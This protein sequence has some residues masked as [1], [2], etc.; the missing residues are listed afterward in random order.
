MRP[1]TRTVEWVVDEALEGGVNMVQIRGKDMDAANL[2]DI[3]VKLKQLIGGRALLIVNDRLDIA[4]AS[5]AHGVHLGETGLP[6]AAAR[7]VASPDML[8]GRSVHSLTGALKAEK[9]NPD[10]LIMGTIFASMSHP[11]V[12]PKGIQLLHS[13]SEKVRAPFL[14]IGGIQATNIA[15]VMRA[16]A[17]GAAVISAIYEHNSPRDAASQLIEVMR[18]EASKNLT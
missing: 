6:I 17:S 18:Y 7:E 16:G 12:N 4:M 10:Y 9:E 14:A 3:A 1:A 8:L 13:T 5:R 15:D 11:G 2:L